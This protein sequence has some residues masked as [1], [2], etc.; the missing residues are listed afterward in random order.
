MK[1]LAQEEADKHKFEYKRKTET[2]EHGKETSTTESIPVTKVAVCM[3][4][5]QAFLNP[6]AEDMKNIKSH[7]ANTNQ[8]VFEFEHDHSATEVEEEG[9]GKGKKK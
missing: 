6:S 9:K 8:V 1:K 3:P 7:A 5:Q 4:R 2:S